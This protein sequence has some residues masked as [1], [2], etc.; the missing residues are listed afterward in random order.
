M[1][2]SGPNPVNRLDSIARKSSANNGGVKAG[3]SNADS[4]NIS[5]EAVR[6]AEVDSLRERVAR[7]PDI[8]IDRVREL[9]QMIENGQF[10]TEERINGTV[11][12]ILNELRTRPED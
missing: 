1:N 2:I 12:K 5:P 6:R 10:D 3:K 8:R 7:I 4:V 11:D 9:R